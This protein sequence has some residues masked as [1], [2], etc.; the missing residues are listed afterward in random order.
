M[1]TA[2]RTQ[3]IL[4][5]GFLALT[6]SI[7]PAVAQEKVGKE[8]HETFSVNEQTRLTINNKYGS[9]DVKNWDQKTVDVRVKLIFTD[10][11]DKRAQE[12]SK[13]ILIENHSQGNDISFETVFDAN[14]GESISQLSDAGKQFKIVYT[15]NMPHTVPANLSNKYGSIFVDKLSR[16]SVI[17]LKYGS[18]K[19]NDISS[20][21]K[22]PMSEVN[23][24]YSDG[25]IETSSW[26]K[27]NMKYSKLN[28]QESKA[29]IILSKYSKVF[30]DRGS[31]VI[32]EARY[33]TYE[34]GTV[35]N[36]V[37]NAEYSNFKFQSIG[38]KLNTETKYTDV[39]IAFMPAGF[40]EIKIINRYGSY[41]VGLEDG[42]SYKLNGLANYGNIIISDNARVNRFNESNELRLEGKVGSNQNSTAQVTIDTKYGT[43]KLTK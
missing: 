2:S 13:L 3:W 36:M 25:T 10:V 38:K 28:I 15:I 21:E 37:T 41:S 26:L 32:S 33:D 8:V 12:L 7:R 19:V 22:S 5:A 16:A 23:M 9:I 20:I 24:A 14:F 6:L 43:V 29:L 27:I 40:E 31:S 34:V 39:K 4:L 42:A 35:A 30:I 18:L 17:D 11:S 1:K